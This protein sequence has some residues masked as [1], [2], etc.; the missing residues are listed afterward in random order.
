VVRNQRVVRLLLV[1]TG[2]VTYLH[3]SQR[4]FYKIRL[5]RMRGFHR[6]EIC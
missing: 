1:I 3:T 5:S 4:S 6:A 2:H